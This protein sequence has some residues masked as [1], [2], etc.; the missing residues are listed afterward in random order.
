MCYI[1]I[2]K[3]VVLCYIVT[4]PFFIESLF[5]MQMVT[6][7]GGWIFDKPSGRDPARAAETCTDAPAAPALL[8]RRQ[9]AGACALDGAH[10]RLEH[11][12]VPSD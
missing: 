2:C 9:R 3:V 11:A 12:S 6:R 5:E 7:N 4:V 1:V 10:A 8:R